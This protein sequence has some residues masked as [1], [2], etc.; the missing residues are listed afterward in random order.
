MLLTAQSS[1]RVVLM[2][3]G[4][5]VKRGLVE[6]VKGVGHHDRVSGTSTSRMRLRHCE[7][8][9]RESRRWRCTM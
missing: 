6:L 7:G 3:V 1:S 8:E 9:R 4:H 2:S 5:I